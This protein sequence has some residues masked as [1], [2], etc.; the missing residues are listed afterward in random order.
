MKSTREK[1]LWD[2]SHIKSEN[3][4]NRKASYPA[5]GRSWTD[6]LAFPRTFTESAMSL[7]DFD[8]EEAWTKKIIEKYAEVATS[9]PEGDIP[10]PEGFGRKKDFWIMFVMSA[11]FGSILGFTGLLILNI[12]DEVI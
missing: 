1:S 3:G 10:I 5:F 2:E 12:V 9:G 8:S 7:I 11:V 4:Y 6:T